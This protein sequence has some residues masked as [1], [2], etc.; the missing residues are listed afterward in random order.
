[1]FDLIVTLPT[2]DDDHSTKQILDKIKDQ[3]PGEDAICFYMHP[4]VTTPT[5][6]TPE[7]TMVS[8]SYEPLI[9]RCLPHQINEIESM[10]EESWTIGGRTFDSP[11]LELED[12]AVVLKSK[13]DKDR[14][15]RNRLKLVEVLAL[16]LIT[17]ND[18]ENKFGA[19]KTNGYFIWAGD[20]NIRK[21][22][23]ELAPPLDEFEW[24]TVKSIVQGI[25]PLRSMPSIR[26]KQ[27]STLSD[28]I[29]I[30]DRQIALLDAEQA[31]AALQI[32]P[33]P[34]RI[35]G[36][37]GTGKTVLLT[38]KAANIHMRFPD[39][40]ILFTFNTQSLYNQVRRLISRFY[41]YNSDTDPDWDFL[42]VR[43]AW[44]GHTKP[45]VYY[46]LCARQGLRPYNFREAR[47]MNRASPFTICCNQVLQQE[48][49]P[50]YDFI[51]IDEAQD[52]NKKYFEILYRLSLSPHQIYWA[53]DELQSLSA[54]EMPGPE[55]LFPKDSDG[56]PLVTL[57]GGP[58][59]GEIEK[60]FVLHKSYR[61]PQDVLML[62]HG[63]GLGIHNPSGCLQML[64]NADSWDALGYVIEEGKLTKGNM[65]VIH[66]PPENSPNPIFDIYDGTEPVIKIKTFKDRKDEFDWV[67]SSIFKDIKN[68]GVAADQI[69]VICLDSIKMKD[70]LP[71]IQKRLQEKQ[72]PST[73]PGLTDDTAAFG[74]AG[75]VT[76]STVFRAKGNEA[77]IV[78]VC[79]FDSLYDY[80]KAIDN[81]NRV[82]TAISRSKAWVRLSGVGVKMNHAK[83]E[84]QKILDD[85]PR[86][87]FEFPDMDVIRRL[88]AETEKRRR[89]V[90]TV[91]SA[92]TELLKTDPKALQALADSNPELLEELLKHIEKAKDNEDK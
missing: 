42:H 38:M 51:L 23:Q 4:V 5:G 28:A 10:D 63:L 61:C 29:R 60:D 75:K 16:P 88:D 66:R 25:R 11:L 52:F 70:Y 19:I 81:R 44:G 48:I 31:K 8:K 79:N 40:K 57:G 1:M 13:F 76:L 43:H 17:K 62:A 36:L 22:F 3:F 27:T 39:K 37:A 34:Q 72:I 45:G 67:A 82:F 18:F 35:R 90:K 74:E 9:I 58:Y 69:V 14:T 21:I 47:R 24:D 56:K 87:R 84:V 6:V 86:F 30:L 26:P 7:L 78:Y 64:E 85:L 68:E 2:F 41:R 53:Y 32:A 15:I 73:I 46:D 33:G 89:A 77:Y 20:N 12:F 92:A 59:P 49:E 54:Q 83:G 55:E 65:V 71:P 80:V 50:E 91:H